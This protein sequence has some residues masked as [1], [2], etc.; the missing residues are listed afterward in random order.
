MRDEG[1][2]GGGGEEREKD[3]ATWMQI[4]VRGAG[5]YEELQG[6]VGEGEG[7]LYGRGR[8]GGR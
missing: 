7:N 8:G 3:A 4:L 5:D 2:K 6:F 1:R